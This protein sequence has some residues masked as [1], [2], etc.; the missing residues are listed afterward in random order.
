MWNNLPLQNN[1]LICSSWNHTFKD[2]YSAIMF[3][4]WSSSWL[5]IHIKTCCFTLLQ[6]VD[7]ET[8]TCQRFDWSVLVFVGQCNTVGHSELHCPDK[9]QHRLVET[10][11]NRSLIVNWLEKRETTHFDNSNGCNTLKVV[12]IVQEV[13]HI[14]QK[15][16]HIAQKVAR[17]AQEVAILQ[18]NL[19][20][21][22]AICKRQVRRNEMTKVKILVEACQ[23]ES[24][25]YSPLVLAS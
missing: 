18:R 2:A 6:S 16:V 4:G 21:T 19:W 22:V 9:D 23:E 5:A 13:V 15:V 8:S 11:A 14:A 12:H 17:I 20:I 7:N 24:K 3:K 25:P 1:N 10:L